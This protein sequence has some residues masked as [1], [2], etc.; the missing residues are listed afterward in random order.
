M[1]MLALFDTLV[2][3]TTHK[4]ASPGNS[5]RAGEGFGPLKAVLRDIIAVSA[6]RKVRS[7]FPTQNP[8]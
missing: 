4:D 3:K 1:A 2:V 5:R 7:Q 8:L 6:G